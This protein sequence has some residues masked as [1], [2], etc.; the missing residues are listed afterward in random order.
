MK[1]LTICIEEDIYIRARKIAVE[2]GISLSRLVAGY[3]RSLGQEEEKLQGARK[4]MLALF[5]SIKGFG[6]KKKPSRDEMHER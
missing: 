6:V 4:K 5:R 3:L 2:Q 1:N